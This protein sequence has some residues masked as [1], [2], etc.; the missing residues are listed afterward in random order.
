MLASPKLR[1]RLMLS[2]STRNCVPLTLASS[3]TGPEALPGATRVSAVAGSCASNPHV[4]DAAS[5]DSDRLNTGTGSPSG[6][7]CRVT[8]LITKYTLR[9]GTTTD[10]PSGGSLWFSQKNSRW[11]LAGASA[12]N[13][14][15]PFGV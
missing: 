15:W 4:Q 9:M 10:S 13:S 1:S 14:R 7:R 12:A 11:A 6:S 2:A 8:L 5:S 3:S